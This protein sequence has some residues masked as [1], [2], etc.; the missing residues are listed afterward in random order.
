MMDIKPKKLK[1]L[2][3]DEMEF[4]LKKIKIAGEKIINNGE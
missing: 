4:R 3:L 1:S 2:I